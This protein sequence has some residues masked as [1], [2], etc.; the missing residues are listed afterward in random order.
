[1]YQTL[2]SE[3]E[4]LQERHQTLLLSNRC[5]KLNDQSEDPELSVFDML[6][7]MPQIESSDHDRTRLETERGMSEDEKIEIIDIT[8]ESEAILDHMDEDQQ[9]HPNQNESILQ[10]ADS[11]NGFSVTWDDDKI[12]SGNGPS[13]GAKRSPMDHMEHQKRSPLK[14]KGS[15]NSSPTRHKYVETVRGKK[16]ELL[17]GHECVQCEK[18]YALNPGLGSGKRTFCDCVSRHRAKHE[19]PATPRHFWDIDIPTPRD[20]Y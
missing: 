12:I 20:V 17:P 15:P 10:R 6:Q 3:H 16:R 4:Q 2:Q 9:I 14:D 7:S 19:Q 11:E 8:M 18:F 5:D 13:N 1:M